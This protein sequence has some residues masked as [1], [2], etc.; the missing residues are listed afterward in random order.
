MRD[1]QDEMETTGNSKL[2]A[3]SSRDDVES[4]EQ[5]WRSVIG[6]AFELSANFKDILLL[7][8]ALGEF[9][10]TLKNA[11]PDRY[12]T[13]KP[14]RLRNLTGNAETEWERLAFGSGKKGCR[15]RVRH[16]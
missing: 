10:E 6:V 16:R 7:K 8:G 13:A 15:G 11:K 5:S 3:L 9:V 2:L 1:Q 4:T 14:A 12:A